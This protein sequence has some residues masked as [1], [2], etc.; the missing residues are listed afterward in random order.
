MHT[1]KSLKAKKL[2]LYFFIQQRKIQKIYI[3][4]AHFGFNNQF[5]KVMRTLANI[6]K[7]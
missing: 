6:S 5:I 7:N 2:M 4:L 1:V 3:I